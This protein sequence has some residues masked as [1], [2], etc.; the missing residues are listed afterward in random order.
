MNK[1]LIHTCCGP[2]F[3]EIFYDILEAK[4]VFLEKDVQ[5][6]SLFYNPN[7]QPKMEYEKRKKTLQSFCNKVSCDL[8]VVDEYN[9]N[10]FVNEVVNLEER[11]ESRCEYCYYT[12]LKHTFEYAK[13][14]GY[15]SVMTTLS[16]SPYQNQELIKKVGDKLSKEYNI[17]Y[18]HLDYTKLFR[19]GQK[20][21]VDLKMYRQKY[22]GCIFSID[23]G[24]WEY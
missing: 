4:E 23:S 13:T 10:K 6:T 5:I 9:L 2:C 19:Q 14:L 11:F 7:I 1:I 22:C 12:R 17:R 24:K 18:I 8:I 16:I 3:V 15:T 21:A 20:R